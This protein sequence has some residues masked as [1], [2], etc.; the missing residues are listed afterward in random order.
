MKSGSDVLE[1]KKSLL[2]LPVIRAQFPSLVFIGCLGG[3]AV[4]V[5]G[6]VARM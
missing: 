2:T 4:F 6:K 3:E 1:K 5:G